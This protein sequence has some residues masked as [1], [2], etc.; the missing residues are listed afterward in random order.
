MMVTIKFTITVFWDCMRV[1]FS[2]SLPTFRRKVLL[3]FP[4]TKTGI[5]IS[6]KMSVPIYQILWLQI[7]EGS[8]V[9]VIRYFYIPQ[10][11]RIRTFE[12][13]YVIFCSLIRN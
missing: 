1:Q 8:N 5:A 6:F 10:I 7:P 13:S 3:Q 2:R 11:N 4:T 12:H 9:Q